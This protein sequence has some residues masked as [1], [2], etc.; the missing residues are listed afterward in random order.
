VGVTIDEITVADPPDAWERAGFHVDHDGTCCI[1]HVRVRLVG[2][3]GGR[4]IVGWSL[5]DMANN[6]EGEVVDIDGLTTST[7]DTD[8]PA[9]AEHPNGCLFIDHLVV[10][11]PA[12]D[13]TTAAFESHGVRC[14]RTRDSDT[15]GAP[16]QQ[17]F[18]RLGEVILEVIG[19]PD[20]AGEGPA[21]FYGLAHTVADLDATKAMLGDDLGQ[22]KDAVQPG[23]RIATLRHKQVGMSVATAFMSPEPAVVEARA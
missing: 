23:R 15:Y 8:P 3:D 18:F 10:A 22:P 6:A 16:M 11:T 4:R 21:V 5:R 12:L 20:A 1:G 17:R 19:A 7:S 2:R 9:P 13:R 14:L